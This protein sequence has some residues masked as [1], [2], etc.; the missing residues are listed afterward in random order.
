MRVRV[1]VGTKCSMRGARARA[2]YAQ[3][4]VNHRWYREPLTERRIKEGGDFGF[5][6]RGIEVDGRLKKWSWKGDCGATKGEG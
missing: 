2:C 6:E 3:A 1:R 5:G 4:E